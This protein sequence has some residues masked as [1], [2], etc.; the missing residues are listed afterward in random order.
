V[1][2]VLSEKSQLQDPLGGD[3][4]GCFKRGSPSCKNPFNSL[5]GFPTTNTQLDMQ[6]HDQMLCRQAGEKSYEKNGFSVG[7]GRLRRYC[8]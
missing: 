8:T 4:I 5:M 3:S 7:E 1:E 2:D 6:S